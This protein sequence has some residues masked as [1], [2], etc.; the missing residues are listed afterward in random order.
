MNHRI[1]PL[2]KDTS[3]FTMHVL[4][5]KMVRYTQTQQL[6]TWADNVIRLC[7]L[8]KELTEYHSL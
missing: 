4:Q 3:S 6:A 8:S 5:Q 7:L 1:Y 2:V